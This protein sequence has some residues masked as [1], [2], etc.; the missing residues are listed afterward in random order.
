[1]IML[2]SMSDTILIM[3]VSYEICY[4]QNIFNGIFHGN[5]II[6]G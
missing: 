1:M 2:Q 3:M 6:N 4:F 5:S